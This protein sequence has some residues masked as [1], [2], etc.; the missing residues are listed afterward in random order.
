MADAGWVRGSDGIL[1]HQA[2]GERFES[3]IAARP[4]S[5]ADKIITL[6]ADQWK[7]IGVQ[8][9]IQCATCAGSGRRPSE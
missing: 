8:M 6:M 3:K 1:V 7:A 4:T 9:D 2:S 5:G